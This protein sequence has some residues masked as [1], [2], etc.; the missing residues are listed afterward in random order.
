MSPIAGSDAQADGLEHR[1][2]RGHGRVVKQDCLRL[3]AER[4]RVGVVEEPLGLREEF[5]GSDLVFVDLLDASV[6][7]RWATMVRSPT[8]G[9][10]GASRTLRAKLDRSATRC[11]NSSAPSRVTSIVRPAALLMGRTCRRTSRRSASPT[12]LS[13]ESQAV[14]LHN[15][16]MA[17]C[18]AVLQAV[19]LRVTAGYRAHVIR[20]EA[21]CAELPGGD[22]EELLESLDASRERRNEASYAAG[23]VSR[24][25]V[26]EAREATTELIEL[27]RQFPAPHGENMRL[28]VF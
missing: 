15:A 18:D 2:A 24:A 16:T 8:S 5:A 23:I 1:V 26:T 17:A 19:G 20:L 12:T 28:R 22:T 21:A 9:V 14:L 27:T 3:R 13:S 4:G 11:R 7:H 25:S 10:V 6:G